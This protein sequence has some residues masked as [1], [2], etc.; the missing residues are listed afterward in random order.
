[1][2][3]TLGS[4]GS[5]T[6]YYR[7]TTAGAPA[8]TAA[9]T[10]Y[11]SATQSHTVKAGPLAR[12]TLSPSNTSVRTGRSVRFT[13]NGADAYGNA[14]PVSGV[15]WSVSPSNLGSFSS[16]SGASATF[17]GQTTGSGT[18]SAKVGTITGTASVTVRR[19]SASGRR[20]RP[21]PP[22]PRTALLTGRSMQGPRPP[23]LVA[24]PT[25]A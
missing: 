24:E 9:A 17:T 7:D 14:V 4:S 5:S 2:P 1:M 11:T 10:G 3:V 19:R 22:R 8:V 13:A 25:L 6:F 16:I 12:L 18:V 20:Q 23:V 15:A 21:P